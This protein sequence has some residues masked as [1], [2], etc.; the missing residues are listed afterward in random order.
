MFGKLRIKREFQLNFAEILRRTAEI[1]SKI[2]K[3]FQENF[4]E[5]P[6]KCGIKFEEALMSLSKFRVIF[7]KIY[8]ETCRKC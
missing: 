4:D 5:I 2:S 6:R 8:A 1:L 7:V 3:N